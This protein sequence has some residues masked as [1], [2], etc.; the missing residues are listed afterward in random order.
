MC[1]YW[2]Q[3]KPLRIP[4]IW[5]IYKIRIFR[6]KIKQY[7]RAAGIKW[8]LLISI[9]R[10][11]IHSIHVIMNVRHNSIFLFL[12][13][14]FTLFVMPVRICESRDGFSKINWVTCRSCGRKFGVL[15]LNH[16]LVEARSSLDVIMT[17][18][19][20]HQQIFQLQI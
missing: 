19:W 12:H 9:K 17:V 3:S 16:N 10:E 7:L 13:C 14:I 11:W 4:W 2:F 6:L 15:L 20:H 8:N 18:L 1:V 5:I